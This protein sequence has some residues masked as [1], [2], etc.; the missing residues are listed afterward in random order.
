M[1]TKTKTLNETLRLAP[2]QLKATLTN[3]PTRTDNSDWA[4]GSRHYH[5]LIERV[6]VGPSNS[7]SFEYSQGTAYTKAPSLADLVYCT[8]ND[9][10][11]AQTYR[12]EWEMAND[13][14]YE[15]TDRKSHQRI[16]DIYNAC[17]K[18]NDW[19]EETFSADEIEQLCELF[20]DY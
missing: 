4:Y 17:C 14:G 2:W 1:T 15:V 18:V 13:Y 11:V 8:L 9:A 16:V 6:G 12:D 3:I 20:E 7:L 19:L 5:C 10:R